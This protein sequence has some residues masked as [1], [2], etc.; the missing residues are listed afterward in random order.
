MLSKH[1]KLVN[2]VQ[3]A[4]VLIVSIILPT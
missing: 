4:F 1:L 2:N 3:D